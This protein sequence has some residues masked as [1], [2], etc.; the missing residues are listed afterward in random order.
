MESSFS[1]PLVRRPKRATRTEG[2]VVAVRDLILR[3]RWQPGEQLPKRID[4]QRTLG[5]SMSTVQSALDRLIAD[6]FVQVEPT[7]GTYVHETPPHLKRLAVVFSYQQV[8]EHPSRWVDAF[9]RLAADVDSIRP[10]K[11][12]I[13]CGV[14]ADFPSTDY[15]RLIEDVR[16]HRI[17]GIIFG[18]SPDLVLKTPLFENSRFPR[19][20]LSVRSKPEIPENLPLVTTDRI[21]WLK[22]AMERLAIDNCHK[23]AILWHRQPDLEQLKVVDRLLVRHKM[24]NRMNWRQCPGSAH[25][26][27]AASVTHLLLDRSREDRP[28]SL[29]V[30]DEHLLEGALEGIR[31]AGLGV[32]ED[33]SVVAHA[34]FPVDTANKSELLGVSRLG[35]DTKQILEASIAVIDALRKGQRRLDDQVIEPKFAEDLAAE[36]VS[37]VFAGREALV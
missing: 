12:A 31:R 9:K 20:A 34:T 36:S 23:P 27:Q 28:D 13:Y 8:D 18:N 10:Y 32:R 21:A 33:I 19:V 6:G 35:F 4:L 29:I 37:K 15:F 1:K 17:A 3:G 14:R 2:A 22:M 25:I 7:K 26:D 30:A 24:I 11:L 16:E 5:V